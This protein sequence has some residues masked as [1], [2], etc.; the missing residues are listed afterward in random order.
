MNLSESTKKIK[1]SVEEIK[2]I[3]DGFD[4]VENSIQSVSKAVEEGGTAFEKLM[5][6]A[7]NGAGVL[8]AAIGV[9]NNI[10]TPVGAITAAASALGA[11]FTFVSEK[12][13]EAQKAE[14]AYYDNITKRVED[15]NQ[16][17][18][19][20]SLKSKQEL[21]EID[22]LKD[23]YKELKNYM[24]ENGAI[25]SNR[26]RAL[27]LISQINSVLPE[28]L[29]I[30]E[31]EK[32]AWQ[33]AGEALEDYMFK[34]QAAMLLDD[35]QAEYDETVQRW[36]ALLPTY[37]QKKKEIDDAKAELKK[38][39]QQYE[40]IE[41]NK[42]P[43]DQYGDGDQNTVLGR[44][45]GEILEKKKEI[46]GLEA[47]LA[48][49]EI[50]IFGYEQVMSEYNELLDAF[51]SGDDTYIKRIILQVQTQVLTADTASLTDL[52][53][54]K[55]LYNDV[56]DTNFRRVENG[57]LNIRDI[58][59]QIAQYIASVN[60]LKI[61]M[62]EEGV[63]SEEIQQLLNEAIIKM[64]LFG[65][66]FVEMAAEAFNMSEEDAQQI[67]LNAG[68]TIQ[69]NATVETSE[70][71]S[72]QAREQGLT[73][74][75]KL[76]MDY[77]EGVDVG[78][79]NAIWAR[80]FLNSQGVGMGGT[81]S[82]VDYLA[83]LRQKAAQANQGNQGNQGNQTGQNGQQGQQTPGQ[84]ASSQL[85]SDIQ[86]ELEM[87]MTQLTETG[88]LTNVGTMLLQAIVAGMG[89]VSNLEALSG[90]VEGIKTALGGESMEGEF[91][92]S[93]STLGS[94][95]A[96]GIAAGITSGSDEIS[97]AVMSALQ[98]AVENG[99]AS[100]DSSSP[101]KL[102]RDEIGIPFAQGIGVGISKQMEAVN[103]I[104]EKELA[105]LVET[106]RSTVRASMQDPFGGA[107]PEIIGGYAYGFGG[108]TTTYS[109]SYTFN[110]PKALDYREMRQE[111]RR[112]DQL[113]RLMSLG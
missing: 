22:E 85:M 89:E 1:E 81:I 42:I 16:F 110:S 18:E 2:K 103:A 32:V 49:L 101:S 28:S 107:R 68:I 48:P 46:S 93:G 65:A 20:N 84:Q 61:K 99:K 11:V 29:Q 17:L 73:D 63:S 82:E 7:S 100:I 112:M 72:Q 88:A 109:P 75:E 78:V 38:L 64:S 47:E 26:E 58:E 33:E 27:E 21:E 53:S 76:A 14:Q 95:F 108:N 86:S 30:V 91:R 10:S 15:Y 12:I 5:G 106:A 87:A 98:S 9:L 44:I 24:D 31:N 54:Q 62:Q 4:A 23:K 34:K 39:Q 113:N 43:P 83:S 51:L 77:L 105:N 55:D 79:S 90:A 35:K 60:E 102:T 92:S 74:G 67:L 6:V 94:S 70:G 25:I 69:L 8:Q 41:N 71:A 36:N 80:E 50:E 111:L 19:E 45:Y 57:E 37:L 59:S 40:D 66:D 13:Q 56:L 104:D 52:Q 97:S 3:T 96:S